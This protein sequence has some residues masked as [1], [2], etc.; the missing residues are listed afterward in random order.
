MEIVSAIS[1]VLFHNYAVYVVLGT[2]IL[3]TIWTKFC[4]WRALTHGTQVIRGVYDKKDDPGD[5]S[6]FQALCTAVSGPVGVSDVLWKRISGNRSAKKKS[7]SR[8]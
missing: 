3:F 4:Q 8:R 1:N 6:H 7:S 5:V 2:G